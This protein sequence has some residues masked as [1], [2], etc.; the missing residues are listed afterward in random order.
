MRCEIVNTV[1]NSGVANKHIERIVEYVLKQEKK[2]GDVTIQ[3]VGDARM[4]RLNKEYRGKDKTTDVLSFAFQEGEHMDFFDSTLG[5]IF[6]CP[7]QLKRQSV[8][9]KVPYKEEFSRM[10]I[11]GVLHILGYDH[12]EQKEAEIMFARQEKYLRKML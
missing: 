6:L 1:K 7:N 11:H 5:D 4:R 3:I 10:L 2:K 9:F 8:Y 12:V